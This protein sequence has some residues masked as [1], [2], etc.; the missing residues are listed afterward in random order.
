MDFSTIESKID[1]ELCGSGEEG[2]EGRLEEK[3]ET[4]GGEYADWKEFV[5]D[6]DLVF[7]NAMTY[8]HAKTP[9]YQI[10]K[11]SLHLLNVL[12]PN[13]FGDLRYRTAHF[14]LLK[15]SDKAAFASE[16]ARGTTA[17]AQKQ[18][19]GQGAPREPMD[20]EDFNRL[21]TEVT[22]TL[23]VPVNTAT[24]AVGYNSSDIVNSGC[25]KL[26]RPKYGFLYRGRDS[27]SMHYGHS[28]APPTPVQVPLSPLVNTGTSTS[29][30]TAATVPS[31]PLSG[32]RVKSGGRCALST[33]SLSSSVSN[34]A[35]KDEDEEK[36]K[37]GKSD[38]D[39]DDDK[40]EIGKS[41]ST[42]E[43]DDNDEDYSFNGVNGGTSSA[44][45][46]QRSL[47]RKHSEETSPTPSTT[48]SLSKQQQQQPKKKQAIG[49]KQTTLDDQGMMPLTAFTNEVVLFSQ[50][51]ENL[52]PAAIQD[53]ETL[54]GVWQ[55]SAHIKR[56]S[57]VYEEPNVLPYSLANMN[58]QEFVRPP[59]TSRDGDFLEALKQVSSEG[60]EAEITRGR[61]RV[62]GRGRSRGRV[63][64]RGRGRGKRRGRG[65]GR[66]A[67]TATIAVDDDDDD[68]GG[69]GDGG[70]NN[71][72]NGNEDSENDI[73]G[74]D[75]NNNGG[76]G[77]EVVAMTT[78][79][80][81]VDSNS[82]GSKEEMAR[83]SDNDDN[84]EK[85]DSD[86]S[87]GGD[88]DEDSDEK[89]KRKTRKSNVVVSKYSF[90]TRN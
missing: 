53:S 42:P 62:R 41:S 24:Y 29:A 50:N 71:S 21:L 57:A 3:H 4:Y 36:K 83:E 46:C 82:E 85:D 43:H 15:I 7:S 63:S 25:E 61:G 17:I 73:N 45:K 81:N 27:P 19:P 87:N 8:N 79:G 10:A 70:D 48:D 54:T 37:K 47:K 65:R 16:V 86:S 14:G 55:S 1:K 67:L 80:N 28:G 89:L 90:R 72:D 13:T 30:S 18:K 75:G 11:K 64:G 52:L 20:L 12:A 78:G 6:L 40:T 84:G 59:R 31:G 26:Q 51:K 2:G 56:V 32:Y 22:K 58:V 77:G 44:A 39:N 74:D 68:G 76:G 23:C 9:F 49:L 34:L 69:S 88:E 35:D 33:S 60:C 66:K 5:G 38:D